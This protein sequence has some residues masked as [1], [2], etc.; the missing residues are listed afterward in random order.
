MRLSIAMF[1]GLSLCH[2][3]ALAAPLPRFACHG[4]DTGFRYELEANS[5]GQEDSV[6][7][8]HTPSSD[9][10]FRAAYYELAQGGHTF[11]FGFE[12]FGE[13]SELSSITLRPEGDGFT[14]RVEHFTLNPAF[15][16]RIHREAAHC[17]R[18]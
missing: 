7:T 18:R 14:A 9:E 4:S 3:P 2:V 11:I 6:V 13:L 12:D 17:T 10:P 1:T 5:I 16:R 15:P 8:I